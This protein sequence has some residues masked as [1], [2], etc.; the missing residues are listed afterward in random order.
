MKK[1][2]KKTSLFLVTAAMTVSAPLMAWALE[3]DIVILH[4]NDIHC[5]INDNIGFAGLAQIKKDALAR[6]PNVAL[7]DA[8]DAIQGAPIGK[9]SRGLAVVD[10]MNYL[11]YDFCIPGNHEFDYGMDRFLELVPLQRAGYYCANLVYTGNNKQVLPGYK[12]MQYEDTKVAFIG[13]STPESL[14]T[15][16]PTFFQNEK[17]KYIYSFC[18]DKSG[19]KLYKQLQKNVDKARKDGADYVFIVGHLGMDGTTP[20]WSSE[21]VAKNTQGVDAVIDGHSHERFTRMVKNKVGKDVLLAQTG[22]KLKTVGELVITPDGKLKSQLIT[23]SNGKDANIARV[24]AQEI[25]TYEP[26]LKQPVGEALVQLRSNDPATGERIVRNREC[27]LGD[28]VADA[29]RAVLDCDVVLVNGG[30]IRNEIKTGVISYNDLL[31]AFPF[32]NMC[33]VLEV[34]GQQILDALEMGAI[35]YPEESGGFM[36]VSGLSYTIDSSVPSSIE[37]DAKGNFVRVAGARRVSDVKIGGKPL[38]VNKKYTVGGTSYMLKSGGDGMTMFKGAHLVQD[39]MMSDA[40]TIMGYLQ[41]HLNGKVGEQY[42]NP[43]GDGRIVIK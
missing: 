6:T 5:G 42:A 32:G 17:G 41:N 9:L 4:T 11:G 10:I 16:T 36:Q 20:Q 8:G 28:F 2:W 12:I 1:F 18:E 39:E 22:T 30:S 27:S 33:V 19:N 21:S 43:Y 23:E 7:V 26:L 15:S 24:I 38:D 13:A 35:S 31:E 34:N 25:K 37:L 14:T 3:H 40:D 29:Y